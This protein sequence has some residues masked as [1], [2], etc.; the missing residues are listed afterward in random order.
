MKRFSPQG[1]QL[2]AYL[3]VVGISIFSLV[4]VQ[5]VAR[6]KAD[7]VEA[8]RA[9]RSNEVLASSAQGAILV[10]N[11]ANENVLGVRKVVVGS[12]DSAVSTTR[13]LT[14]EGGLTFP[15]AKLV[16]GEAFRAS[17]QYLEDLPFRDCNLVA[18]Q[19][20]RQIT[21]EGQKE[22]I[23]DLKAQVTKAKEIIQEQDPKLVPPK[24]K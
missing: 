11:T 24:V 23:A 5:N 7:N 8:I 1:Y 17:K 13:K 12:Y 20:T 16:A 19:L 22:K 18:D 21:D 10:C 6:D 4:S 3:L 14:V 9:E 2:F 15:Q